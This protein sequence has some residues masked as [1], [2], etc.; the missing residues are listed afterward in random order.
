MK[1][2]EKYVGGKTYMFPNGDI[3]TPET[4]LHSFPACLTFTHVVE[5]DEGGEVMFA[6]Q[7]LSALKSIYNIDRSLSDEEA[8]AAIQTIINTVPEYVESAEDRQATALEAIAE[9]ATSETTEVIN[10][11]LGE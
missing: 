5:T 4:I 6:M 2:L 8:I 3:A 9:G 1:I 7:N 10:A 11:L